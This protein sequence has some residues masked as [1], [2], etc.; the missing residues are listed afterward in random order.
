MVLGDSGEIAGW[1]TYCCRS[2]TQL[3]ISGSGTA[4]PAG[5]ALPGSYNPDD[6]NGVRIT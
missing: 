3:K 5:I 4:N 2:C 1:L 6:K